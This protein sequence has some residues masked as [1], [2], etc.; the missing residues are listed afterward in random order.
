MATS[1][2]GTEQPQSVQV[3]WI[4]TDLTDPLQR[5]GCESASIS[6]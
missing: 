5:V 3:S 2:R 1:T 6:D 4:G